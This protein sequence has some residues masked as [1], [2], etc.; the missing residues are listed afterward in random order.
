MTRLANWRAAFATFYSALK[1]SVQKNG[2]DTI[3]SILYV[4]QW[5]VDLSGKFGSLAMIVFVALA[6]LSLLTGGYLFWLALRNRDLSN[7]LMRCFFNV[8]LLAAVAGVTTGIDALN[9]REIEKR[10]EKITNTTVRSDKKLDKLSQQLDGFESYM[11][12]GT[13]PELLELADKFGYQG[14][15]SNR[16]EVKD[17]LSKKASEL[18][19]LQQWASSLDAGNAKVQALVDEARKHIAMLQLEQAQEK[20]QEAKTMEDVATLKQA[21]KSSNIRI[22]SAR[23]YLMQN[24]LKE[25][26][27][28]FDEAAGL[29]RVLD[30]ATAARIQNVAGEN[31]YGYGIA[32]AG[33]KKRSE[34][35]LHAAIR[36]YDAAL[37]IWE[38][39]KEH[40]FD[41]QETLLSK[42]QIQSYLGYTSTE[43]EREPY[44]EAAL[45]AYNTV[46]MNASISPELRSRTQFDKANVLF[47][48][49]DRTLGQEGINYLKEALV[50][51]DEAAK[52]LKQRDQLFD[53]SGT[54][55]LKGHILLI[56]GTR[57]SGEEA[58][59]YLKDSLAVYDVVLRFVKRQEYPYE[60]AL[61]QM[62]KSEMLRVLGE[63]VSGE[64]VQQY[65]KN[66]LAA[67]DWALEVF[68]RHE[69]PDDWAMV[70]YNRAY[71]LWVRS[72]AEAGVTRQNT[73]Q[74]A[75]GI[76][77]EVLEVWTEQY[78]QPGY[79]REAT[80][81]LA[82]IQEAKRLGKKSA[83]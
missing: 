34:A 31:L 15:R 30:A 1:Q 6:A 38:Q 58:H 25:A 65:L 47:D 42:A 41:E 39:E 55:H 32:G 45:A 16:L 18:K 59:Q 35:A 5:A 13:L 27:A 44:W 8:S 51:N 71:T 9:P 37:S 73:L 2:K 63:Q 17:Y 40:P 64:E 53:W 12:N 57:T 66:S 20:L 62:H 76:I 24:K 61:A 46:L 80:E 70:Q 22:F 11:K 60:W 19:E 49:G 10:I 67:C 79:Y 68:T 78:Y 72:K 81:I 77:K 43:E 28:A 74:Q 50:S 3:F 36:H 75:E 29:V 54:Q 7:R 14:N 52:T 69:T 48:M 26:D 21:I 56:L 83:P 33:E 82:K 23:T 4:L